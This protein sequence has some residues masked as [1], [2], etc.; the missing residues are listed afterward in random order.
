MLG[1]KTRKQNPLRDWREWLQLLRGEG[2]K[3][4]DLI[5]QNQMQLRYECSFYLAAT[6]CGYKWL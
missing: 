2:A 6:I 1:G 5:L 4:R 3:M